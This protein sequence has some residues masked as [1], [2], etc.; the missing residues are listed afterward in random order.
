MRKAR[1][2]ELKEHA[3]QNIAISYHPIV[4]HNILC[5]NE[6]EQHRQSN[7]TNSCQL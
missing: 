2:T 5:Q 7:D 6:Y 3:L 4:R 1:Y